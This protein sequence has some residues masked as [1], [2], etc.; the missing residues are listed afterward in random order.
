MYDQELNE[1]R[2]LLQKARAI[3]KKI[4]TI[5]DSSEK[6]KLRYQH[7]EILNEARRIYNLLYRQKN[8]KTEGEINFK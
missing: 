2:K 5:K 4:K 1:W 8:Q 7:K 6:E 3:Y